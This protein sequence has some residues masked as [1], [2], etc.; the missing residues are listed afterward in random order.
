MAAYVHHV[1]ASEIERP[2]E[3]RIEMP[4]DLADDSGALGAPQAQGT[5]P[6]DVKPKGFWGSLFRRKK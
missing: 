1:S 4:A 5:E 2:T 6:S 3:P